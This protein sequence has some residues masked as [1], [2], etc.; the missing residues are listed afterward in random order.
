M[1]KYLY[2]GAAGY[3]V[4]LLINYLRNKVAAGQNLEITPLKIS[5]DLPKTREALYLKIFYDITLNLANKEQ[6]SV[7]VKSLFLTVK[8]NN[9]NFGNIERDLNFDVEEMQ[10]KQITVKASFFTLSAIG[11]IKDLIKN[12]FNLNVN[13]AGF[14]DTDLGRVDINFN[15]NI[16]DAINGRRAVN[17]Y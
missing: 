9:I 7:N 17:G 4:F 10:E 12:G 14:I 2:W 1:K 13:V 8:T 5:I 16:G 11:I 15:K 6:A 3:A